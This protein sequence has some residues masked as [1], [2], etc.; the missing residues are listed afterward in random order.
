M[1]VLSVQGPFFSRDAVHSCVLVFFQCWVKVGA[2]EK[3]WPGLQL[4]MHLVAHKAAFVHP[5]EPLSGHQ[6][7]WACVLAGSRV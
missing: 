3:G 7:V 6:R 5:S 4:S 1:C 2:R